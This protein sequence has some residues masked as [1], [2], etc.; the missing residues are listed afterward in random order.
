MVPDMEASG[1]EVM[2][3]VIGRAMT[4][5]GVHLVMAGQ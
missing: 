4:P 5:V 2:G 1:P 3:P